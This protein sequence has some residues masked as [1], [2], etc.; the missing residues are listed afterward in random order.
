MSEHVLVT[1][2]CGFV[3][4]NLV[5]RLLEAGHEV[6][7]LDDFRTGRREYLDGLDVDILEGDICDEE[8]VVK[9]MRDVDSV[10]HLAAAGSVLDSVADPAANFQANAAGTFSVLNAARHAGVER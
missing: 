5:P 6:R 3:G 9:V 1:G 7:V 4:A 2:G 8:T 10:I